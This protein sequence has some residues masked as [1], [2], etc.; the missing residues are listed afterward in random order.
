MLPM[1][2]LRLRLG[3]AILVLGAMAGLLGLAGSA[4]GAPGLDSTEPEK[5][6]PPTSSSPDR[7]PLAVATVAYPAA[8]VTPTPHPAR[9]VARVARNVAFTPP[10]TCGSSHCS[11]RLDVYAPVEAGPYPTVVLVR[12]G[13][14]GLGGR[15]Y[16]EGFARELASAGMVVF[17]AD[18]RDFGAAGGGYPEAFQDVACAIRFAR[19]TASRYGGDGSSIVLVG[20]SL[21]GYVGS[22][23]A[24]DQ[25]EMGGS[26]LAAGQ[27]RPDA[28]VGLAGTYLL[29]APEVAR[30][31]DAFFGGSRSAT[32]PERAA[33]DPFSS[34][35]RL[36]IPVR[37]VAGD[38]DAVVNPIASS[39]LERLLSGLGWD[40][41]L[42]MV[43]RAGHSS[44]VAPSAAGPV[45]VQAVLS[46]IGAEKAQRAAAPAVP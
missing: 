9:N 45:S 3:L 43:R 44:L 6:G 37:L 34:A 5:S 14:T 27:G 42:T 33:A 21:G 18:M 36:S 20:H 15:S 16:L 41:R 29:T 4:G 25:D 23:V 26:C 19:S 11:V 46:A 28:F 38:S 13:P 10:V 40:V 1:T 22:V 30:D 8:S 7:N 31:L 2:F 12:G 17:N 24:L 39:S 35:G 32:R